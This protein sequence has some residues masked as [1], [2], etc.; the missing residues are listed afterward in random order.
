[1]EM[2]TIRQAAKLAGVSRQTILR[3]VT[4]KR[5]T[6]ELHSEAPRPYYM[7]DKLSVRNWVKEFHQ[8]SKKLNYLPRN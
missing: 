6:A 5:I 3:A 7:V 1:M 8:A 4:L 2:I